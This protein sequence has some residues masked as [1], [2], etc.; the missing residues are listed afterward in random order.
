MAFRTPFSCERSRDQR[1]PREKTPGTYRSHLFTDPSSTLNLFL[2]GSS[3]DQSITKALHR[4]F[5]NSRSNAQRFHSI[6]PEVL[7]PEEGL[8]NCGYTSYVV[9]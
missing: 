2:V 9:L 3:R 7:I 1:H 6:R 8:D 5:P 4:Q